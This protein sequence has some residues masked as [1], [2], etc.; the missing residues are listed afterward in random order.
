[1][2]KWYQWF[3]LSL[4]FAIGGILNYFDGKRIIAAVIQVSITV[5]LGFI[6][7][8]CEQKGEKGRKVFEYISIVVIVLLIIGVIILVLSALK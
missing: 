2:K 5:I 3:Y 6:Q 7:F 8:L 1:M 4:I